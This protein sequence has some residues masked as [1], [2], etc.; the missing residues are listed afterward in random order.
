M[1][2]KL[3]RPTIVLIG[4]LLGLAWLTPGNAQ[5]GSGQLQE[6]AELYLAN[7]QVCH[8]EKGQGRVGATLAQ[9]WPSIR[10]DLTIRNVITVG[11]P[12]SPMPAWS[13]AYGGPLSETQIESLVAYILSWETGQPF[14]YEPAWTPT[15]HPPITPVADIEGDPN[16]GVLLFDE[17]CTVCHGLTGEGRIGATLAKDWPSIRPD[18]TV[19]NVIS[20]GVSGSVMPA[21][22]QANGGPLTDQEIADITAYILTLPPTRIDSGLP[23]PTPT[24]TGGMS[25]F[26]GIVVTLALFAIVFG[27]VIFV[28]TRNK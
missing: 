16:V 18:L 4:L 10:P 7:C 5:S 19:R 17:N 22:S 9:N 15:P 23:I 2:T 21:W 8:G 11:V 20:N 25:G 3:L 14:V 27:I 28:T 6:G 24:E 26:A 1:T 13:Q 12:G